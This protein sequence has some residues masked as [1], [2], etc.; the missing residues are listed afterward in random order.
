M[1]GA[2][3]NRLYVDGEHAIPKQAWPIRHRTKTGGIFRDFPV[4]LHYVLAILLFLLAP[5]SLLGGLTPR[6]GQCR[7]KNPTYATSPKTRTHRS[8]LPQVRKRAT[9]NDSAAKVSSKRRTEST[10]TL[11]R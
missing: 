6:E 9:A 7:Q 5:C 11:D 4:H 1:V 3:K 10:R 2:D 8:F